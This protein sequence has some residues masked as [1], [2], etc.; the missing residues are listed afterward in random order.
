MGDLTRHFSTYELCC[1]CAK[2]NRNGVVP[3]ERLLALLEAVR[4]EVGHPIRPTSGV[5]CHAHNA[6]VDGEPHSRHLP[7]FKDAVDIACGDSY[8]RHRLVAALI[9][10][11][12]TA[13]KLYPKHIHA[14]C[15]PGAPLFIV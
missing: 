8:L 12:A 1:P 3:S 14:D 6:A 9:K 4:E 13:I 7:E 2:C 15:R 5:R 11:G 10:H